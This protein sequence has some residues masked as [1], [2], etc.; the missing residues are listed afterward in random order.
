MNEITIELDGLEL[1][2]F[3]ELDLTRGINILCIYA[4]NTE[5]S[6]WLSWH[7]VDEIR[8]LIKEQ[9]K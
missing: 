4:G 6:P 5:M 3:Y 7:A 9:L 8:R 2:V 1:D